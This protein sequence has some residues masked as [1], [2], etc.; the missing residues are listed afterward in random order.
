MGLHWQGSLPEPDVMELALLLL[1]GFWE[2]FDTINHD[3]FGII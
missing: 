2:S 3:T 1:L